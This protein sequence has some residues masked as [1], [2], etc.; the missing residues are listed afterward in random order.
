VEGERVPCV[1]AVVHDDQGRLLLVRRGTPP[2]RGLWSVPGGRVESGE[3][4]AE[5][6]VREVQE[7]TGLLVEPG[8]VAGSVERPGLGGTVYVIEDFVAALADGC[9]PSTARPGD[10]ADDVGWFT[11]AELRDLPC[12][13]G[14]LEALGG[15]GVLPR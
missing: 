7:E 6:V 14:L 4:G 15:W 12:V 13:D 3:T 11:A 8:R 9:D 10:D 1:G 5:A 2:G